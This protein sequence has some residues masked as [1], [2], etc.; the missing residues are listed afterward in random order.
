M[1]HKTR[2]NRAKTFIKVELTE[3]NNLGY[4]EEKDIVVVSYRQSYAS[5]TFNGNSTKRQ[6]WQKEA[7][8]RWRII[9]EGRG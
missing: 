8:G 9:Y 3:L 2:V 4:P 6:Y 1:A 5:D 7:D